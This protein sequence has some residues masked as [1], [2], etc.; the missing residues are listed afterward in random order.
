MGLR[1]TGIVAGATLKAINVPAKVRFNQLA[2]SA[3]RLAG[4]NFAFGDRY[5][6]VN[7]PSTSVEA[8]ENGRVAHRYV[9]IVGGPEH[10]S[11]EISAHIQVDQPQ[12]D[13]DGADLDHQEGNHSA[14]CSAIP[15]T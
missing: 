15:A 13:L 7:M 9:A 4:A 11:P 2:S 3:N 1:Q 5:V 14:A 8:I 10:P 12:P 6:V